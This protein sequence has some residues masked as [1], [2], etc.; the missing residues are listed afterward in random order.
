MA[1]FKDKNGTWFTSFRFVDWKGERHQKLKRGFP[2][3]HEALSWEREF[4]QQKTADLTMTFEAFVKI[5]IGDMQNRIRRHTWQTK[6]SII[7]HKLLPYFKDKKMSEITPKDIIQWQNEMI[8]FRDVRGKAFSPVYLK[9]LHNQLSAI[10]NH[11]VRYYELKSNPAAKA[12]NMGKEKTKDM[13]F[14]T[15]D[16]YLKF[17]D[18][19]MDKPVSFY[20]FEM[21]YWCGVRLGEL[22]ALTPA[23]FD[24]TKG[25]V[26][27]TKS[28]QRIEG[29]DVLSDPK[30]PKSNRIIKMPEFL[31]QEMQEYLNS[32]Y[33]CGPNDRIFP[34]TKSYL[35]HEMD[36]G[37]KAQGVKRIRIH[38]LRH[39]H[40]SLLIEMGF[41]AVAIADRVGHESIDITYRYAHLFPSKQTEIA[42][43]LDMERG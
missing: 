7:D 34:I 39:S 32:L 5:Y 41:S 17:A 29:D 11:A 31:V 24:F 21:L 36:R 35:H 23:D 16:E 13:L 20:A 14:W 43:K 18:A 33:G 27:V 2:T 26:S 15:K 10:F 12:G 38:D 8:A 42:D 4:L 1:A 40:V 28:Y 19:M 9:T 3:R 22:L 30:T 37:S 25:T 6:N